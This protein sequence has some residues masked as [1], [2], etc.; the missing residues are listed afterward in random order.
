VLR[1]LDLGFD[2]LS[3]AIAFLVLQRTKPM[4]AASSSCFTCAS[5]AVM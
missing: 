4:V 5:T 3:A 2:Q 1:N